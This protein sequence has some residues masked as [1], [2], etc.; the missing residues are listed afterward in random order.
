M[1]N[2]MNKVTYGVFV[3]TAK[4]NDYDNGCIINTVLQVTDNPEQIIVAVNKIN[5]THDIIMDTGSFNISVLSEKSE[6]DMFKHFGFQS[7]RDVNK[8]EGFTEFK[9]SSNGVSYI[10]KGTN[11]YISGKVKQTIDMGTHTLFVADVTEKEVLN[12]DSSASYEYYHKNIKP[13]ANV[14]ANDKKKWVCT[15]CGYEYEGEDLPEDFICPWC[16]HP[17]SD[18]E[19]L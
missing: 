5:Y 6:F 2:A 19:K 3:L 10:T 15:V 8:F 13:Q 1:I 7:G 17:A 4:K 18:F 9:R 12:E 11:A 16:K 14:E